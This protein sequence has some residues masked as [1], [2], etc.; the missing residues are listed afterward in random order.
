MTCPRRCGCLVCALR[1]ELEPALRC[2]ECGI[3]FPDPDVAG[4]QAVTLCE[5]CRE[6]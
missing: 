1:R 5:D 6:G 2:R 3:W 4:S